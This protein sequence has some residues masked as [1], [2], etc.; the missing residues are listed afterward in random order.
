MPRSQSQKNEKENFM[1]NECIFVSVP[2]LLRALP[3]ACVCVCP[4]SASKAHENH[5]QLP[6]DRTWSKLRTLVVKFDVKL[7]SFS[8]APID[9]HTHT[10]TISIEAYPD[11]CQSTPTNTFSTAIDHAASTTF[12]L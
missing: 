9:R 12:S 7:R 10:I 2:F 6:I 3:S 5:R 8:I 4:S 11:T 1:E